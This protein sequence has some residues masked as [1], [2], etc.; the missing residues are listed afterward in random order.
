MK[1]LSFKTRG[2]TSPQ[3]KPKVYFCHHPADFDLYFQEIAG[4]ILAISDCALC[5]YDGEG[6][7]PDEKAQEATLSQMRLMVLPI[8]A[9][10]LTEPSR[11]MDFEVTIARKHKVPILPLMQESGL[12][13]LFAQRFGKIQY[14]DKNMQDDTAIGYQEKLKK[15]LESILISDTL[16]QKVRDAFVAYIFLSYRKKDRQLAQKLMKLIHQNDFCR[17]IAIWYDEFLI[18]GEDFTDAI[19]AAIQKSRVFALTV[20]PNLLETGNYVLKQ[21]YPYAKKLEKPVFAVELHPTDRRELK[22]LYDILEPL[23]ADNGF[24]LSAYLMEKLGKLVAEKEKKEPE[25][26]YLIGLAYLGGIDVERSPEKAKALI[27]Q[28]AEAGLYEAIEKLARMY[29]DGDSVNQNTEEAIRLLE[30]LAQIDKERYER[31]GKKAFGFEYFCRLWE[32]GNVCFDARQPALAQRSYTYMRDVA[33][34]LVHSSEEE[35]TV[36]YLINSYNCLGSAGY[37]LG[38]KRQS[39]RYYQKATKLALSLSKK[40]DTEHNRILLANCYSKLAYSCYYVLRIGQAK[41]CYKKALALWKNIV[42]KNATAQFRMHLAEAYDEVANLSPYRAKRYYLEA[43]GIR[44]GLMLEENEDKI[45]GALAES[46]SN[47]GFLSA[48]LGEKKEAWEYYRRAIALLE[49][50]CEKKNV[51]VNQYNLANLYYNCG[52]RMK[53]KAF[54]EKALRIYMELDARYPGLWYLKNRKTLAQQLLEKLD[55]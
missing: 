12:E 55:A 36:R 52:S 25:H 38:E 43:C 50:A 31:A 44:E 45:K 9:N 40:A 11:A 22:D 23:D 47:L 17:D 49:P 18:P 39:N 29:L 2:Q 34:E 15:Y 1:G 37:E 30:K 8:T 16:T 5:Y 10:L 42:E 54:L 26:T 41:R 35:S 13:A 46:Y 53:D 7:M 51:F 21:E 6:E 19:K 28:A 27:A 20:T 14:L 48:G 32:L 4:D 24:A 3:G 33:Q